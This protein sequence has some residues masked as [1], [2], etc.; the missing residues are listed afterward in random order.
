M[1]RLTLT[2]TKKTTSTGSQNGACDACGRTGIKPLNKA[3]NK[4]SG[5]SLPHS[6]FLRTNP[7]TGEAYTVCLY[8]WDRV[9]DVRGGCRVWI[10]GALEA[11]DPGVIKR[12]QH[13]FRQ[14]GIFTHHFRDFEALFYA[15]LDRCLP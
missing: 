9:K 12:Y 4:F 13:R 5:T 7:A 10:H 1:P 3:P 2:A 14:H 11:T 8:C 15:Q 6:S